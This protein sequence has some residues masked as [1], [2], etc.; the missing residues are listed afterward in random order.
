MSRGGKRVI[1]LKVDQTNHSLYHDVFL[2]N[3]EEYNRNRKTYIE[4]RCVNEGGIKSVR[5]FNENNWHDTIYG[6]IVRELKDGFLILKFLNQPNLGSSS[7]E[8]HE[9]RLNSISKSIIRSI[10]LDFENCE[11]FTI[12]DEEISEI[13]LEFEKEL[14]WGGGE[15]HRSLKSGFIK[16][17]FN[18]TFPKRRTIENP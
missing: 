14:V 12:Y 4:N 2:Y 8:K 5:L 3:A 11:G 15:L 17:K 9:V 1:K 6:N 13:Q 16:F 18:K 10:D 7:D